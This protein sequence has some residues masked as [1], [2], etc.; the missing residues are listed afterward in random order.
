M[1][2][3]VWNDGFQRQVIWS[4]I[5]GTLLSRLPGAFS[6]KMFGAESGE[7]K[8]A[9]P[10]MRLA[11]LIEPLRS[12]P[13]AD[14][15]DG[16]VEGLLPSLPS[17]ERE[18][19]EVEWNVIRELPSPSNV[20][21]VEEQVGYWAKRSAVV[22]ALMRSATLLNTPV[23]GVELDQ[24]QQLLAQAWEVGTPQDSEAIPLLASVDEQV[25]WWRK[26]EDD[27]YRIP[28][29]FAPL[30]RRLNGGI[31]PGESFYFM[32]P[33]K[34]AKT[35]SLTRVALGASAARFGVAMFSFEMMTKPM[36]A[37]IDRALSRSTKQELRT[38]PERLARAVTGYQAA[39]AGE[40]WLW[41]GVARQ[42]DSVSS[43]RRTVERIRRDGHR[44]DLVVLDYLNIMGSDRT[45]KEKE[46]RH[47]LVGIAR[48]ISAMTRL[49][50]VGAW[51]ATLINRAA[52]DKEVVRK[53]DVAEAYELIA[54]CDGAI[55]ICAPKR[56]R[57]QSL[58]RFFLAALREEED[59]QWAG[60]Y[61][62]DGERMAF[63][64]AP[65]P[66]PVQEGSSG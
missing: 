66:P 33:P 65:D 39:G 30:D 15:V 54:V 3:F 38:D 40:I 42:K 16:L 4:A 51:S 13:G 35:S 34:G 22:Q 11:Q 23:G 19:L 63:T 55:A 52:V 41:T 6:A 32:A 56:L 53:T 25:A 8:V 29:G 28:T 57:A 48:E 62:F 27:L 58:R 2:P 36:R 64:V 18:A 45:V 31:L 7:S 50:G 21:F 49:D 44:I 12:A 47:E 37:R 14:I 60:T 43:I 5:Y 9:S 24:A 26:G 20:E 10:R 1:P 61:L 46:K 59:E 17:A